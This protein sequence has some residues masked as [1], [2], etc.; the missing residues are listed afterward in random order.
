MKGSKIEEVSS[1]KEIN[2]SSRENNSI[3]KTLISS[4]PDFTIFKQPIDS[5]SPEYLDAKIELPGVSSKQEIM[6]DV[7]EDRLVC[8]ATSKNH[9]YTMDI[10]LPY[11]LDQDNC[12]ADF[13][14]ENHL[15]CIKIPVLY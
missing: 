10:F 4:E 5:E 1:H 15:L 11:K 14:R 6:L 8:E 9:K 2:R 13:Y 3:S 7:G 12:N